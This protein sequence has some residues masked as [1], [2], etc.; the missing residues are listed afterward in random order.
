MIFVAGFGQMCNNMLQFGHLYAWGRIR[1]VSVVALRF[2]YKYLYFTISNTRYYHWFTYMFAKYGAKLRLIPSISFLGEKEGIAVQAH[3]DG[4]IIDRLQKSRF[5]LVKG[6]GFRDYDAFLAY[7]E[8]IK[9]LFAFRLDIIQKVNNELPPLEKNKL[10]LGV[11]VRRGDYKTW[12]NGQYYYSDED[13]I[14]IIHSF[15]T[16]FPE[17]SIEILIV[18]NE[19]K[20]PEEKYTMTLPAQLCFLSGNPGED[21]YA[22]STCDYLIGPPSTFSLMAAFYNDANLYWIFDKNQI[23]KKESF[24]KFDYLFQHII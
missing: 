22:L 24:L 21:L 8:E 20:L 7:R 14:R 15:C 2:C 19:K 6:W 12:M 18:S 23:L 16:L 9:L 1:G 17:N 5:I 11:H 4:A 10:R 3:H 13:F